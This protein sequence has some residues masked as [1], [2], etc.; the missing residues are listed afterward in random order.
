V[1]QHPLN[2]SRSKREQSAK[3][4][5]PD[6]GHFP[7]HHPTVETKILVAKAPDQPA[8]WQTPEQA[9]IWKGV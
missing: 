2:E 5:V 9:L 1:N 7:A 6:V 8:V 3:Y 4:S